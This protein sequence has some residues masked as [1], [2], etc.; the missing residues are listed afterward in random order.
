MKRML[1]IYLVNA[2]FSN[3][4]IDLLTDQA[5]S[6]SRTCLTEGLDTDQ[7]ESL[8]VGSHLEKANV[9][10]VLDQTSGVPRLISYASEGQLQNQF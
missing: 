1:R 6:K 3:K 2:S 5:V 7:S 8:L 4:D 9:V 10:T